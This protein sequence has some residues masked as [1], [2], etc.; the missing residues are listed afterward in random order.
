MFISAHTQTFTPERLLVLLMLCRFLDSPRSS[1]ETKGNQK[2]GT[3]HIN[4]LL[5]FSLSLSTTL[6]VRIQ[7]RRS[8]LEVG[9]SVAGLP[10]H[11]GRPLFV[12][13]VSRL[14]GTSMK[15]TA[16]VSFPILLLARSSLQ[17]RL[18]QVLSNLHAC[19]RTY[20]HTYDKRSFNSRQPW[21]LSTR[22]RKEGT[23]PRG[24]PFGLGRLPNLYQCTCKHTH[25]RRR[26]GSRIGPLL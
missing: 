17:Q 10:K 21:P 7:S 19:I 5:F 23:Q 24:E 18:Q 8:L 14:G 4:M 25:H 15:T 16:W 22:V 13:R 1:L 11:F 12:S 20:T 3:R 26:Y 6:E 9:R 2:M